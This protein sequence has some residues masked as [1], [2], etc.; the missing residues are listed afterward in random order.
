MESTGVEAQQ[1]QKRPK[2]APSTKSKDKYS[3]KKISVDTAKAIQGIKDKA[4]KKPF[5][6][7]VKDAEVLAMAVSL[8][9]D[10]EIQLLQEATY[11]EQDRLK[12]AHTEYMQDNGKV[13]LDEFIGRL[14]RGEVK[15]TGI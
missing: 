13:S 1:P 12:L 7:K 15:P 6:R 3:L 10:K 9:S 14:L 8:V 4:N 2:R 11:S 5:G